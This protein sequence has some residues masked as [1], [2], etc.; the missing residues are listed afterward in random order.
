MAIVNECIPHYEPGKRITGH[1]ASAVTGKRF[2]KVA[3]ARL[4]GQ[5]IQIAPCGAG[6]PACGVASMDGAEDAKVTFYGSTF[7]VPVKAGA[8]I[9]AGQEVESDSTGQAIPLDTGKAL[10]LAMNDADSGAD[11]EIKLY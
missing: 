8:S 4:P 7:T 6:E 5:N 2:V 11:A 10:G 1:A 9:T 3:G